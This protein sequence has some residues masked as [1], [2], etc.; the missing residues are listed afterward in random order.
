ILAL[1]TSSILK[2]R[3]YSEPLDFSGL[4]GAERAERRKA[5]HDEALQRLK[6]VDVVFAD[7]D[8]GLIVP[9]AAGKPK[10]NKYVMPDE[11]ADY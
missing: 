9:S 6:G 4:S 8:N 2:A 10:E 5:W 11:I 7:P 3:F 1:E